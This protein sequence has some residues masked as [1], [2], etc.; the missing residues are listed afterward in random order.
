[1]KRIFLSL[2]ALTIVIGSAELQAQDMSLENC[3]DYALENSASAKNAD[4]EVDAALSEIGRIRA[5]GLPQVNA[6]ASLNYNPNI[7]T[8][9]LPPETIGLPPGDDIELAFGTN[10]DGDANISL[11]QMI[12]DGSYF[13][14]LQAARMYKLYSEQERI[15]TNVDVVEAITKS[16]Y[17]VLINEVRAERIESNLDRIKELLDQTELMYQEGFV[18]KIDVNRIK[19]SY[20]NL[21]AQ[22]KQMERL[23]QLSK[24]M[25][26][27]QMGYP[28]D[29]D[30]NLSGKIDAL[31]T[32]LEKEIDASGFSY[33]DRIDYQLLESGYELQILDAKNY[34][35]QYYP[36]LNFVGVLG[37]I[38]NTN[39][40]GQYWDFNDR[41]L[42]YSLLGL[43][44]NVPVFDGL[45]KKYSI[46]KSTIALKQIENNKYMLESSIAAELK[47]KQDA[48][49]NGIEMMEVQK[50]NYDLAQEVY[51]TTD[52]KYQEGVGSNLEL[53]EANNALIDAQAIYFDA[54][55][56]A[57]VA[58]TELEKALGKYNDYE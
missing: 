51:E 9:L 7:R 36:S 48:L 12:F 52:L 11:S 44:L 15:Q 19:V 25:L 58:K 38:T 8:N 33:N 34:R 21:L 6:S 32:E 28:M 16:Y 57:V 10:Y 2:L 14:G 22:D 17:M 1:M 39:D 13:V 47:Q 23:N 3:I 55:Y 18:E 56:D 20:N 30:F 49:N 27:V 35:V 41:W 54:L 50:M 37:S 46:Q 4:L 42:N 40:F 5:T 31:P 24:M 29:E 53:V 26:K 43:R 45:Y